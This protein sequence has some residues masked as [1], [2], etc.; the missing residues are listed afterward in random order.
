M[1]TTC[2]RRLICGYFTLEGVDKIDYVDY[3]D[4]KDA[5]DYIH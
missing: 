5:I 1:H 3:A 2:L 4:D